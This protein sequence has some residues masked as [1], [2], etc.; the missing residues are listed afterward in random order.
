MA[1]DFAECLAL[2]FAKWVF[3]TGALFVVLL[4]FG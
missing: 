1:R 4:M 3:I 2:G